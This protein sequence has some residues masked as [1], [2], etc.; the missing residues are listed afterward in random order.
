MRWFKPF[1]I[2]N[3]HWSGVCVSKITWICIVKN[4]ELFVK[5]LPCD[6]ECTVTS[7]RPVNIRHRPDLALEN[8]ILSSVWPTS[9]C[10][11]EM[12]NK[13]FSWSHILAFSARMVTGGNYDLLHA[14]WFLFKND[15]TEKDLHNYFYEYM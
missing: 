6:T 8:W 13:Y 15:I 12:F 14:I 5:N 4:K 7:F 11:T 9:F 10:W 2:I 3:E 1:L